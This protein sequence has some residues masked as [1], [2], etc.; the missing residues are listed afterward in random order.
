MKINCFKFSYHFYTR[1][2]FTTFVKLTFKITLITQ[3]QPLSE[4]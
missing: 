4:I 1:E 2:G 3:K